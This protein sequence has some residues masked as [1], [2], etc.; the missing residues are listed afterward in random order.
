MMGAAETFLNAVAMGLVGS[1]IALWLVSMFK[2][3]GTDE[4]INRQAYALQG[5]GNTINSFTSFHYEHDVFNGDFQAVLAGFMLWLWWRNGGGDGTKRRLKKL[6]E[7][8]E[9][10]RRTAP[11]TA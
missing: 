11:V 10:T 8:F 5:A 1:G 4:K 7:R 3:F 6:K 2:S 9:G